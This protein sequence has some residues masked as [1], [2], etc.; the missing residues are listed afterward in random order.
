[1][2][3]HPHRSHAAVA[4]RLRLVEGHVRSVVG[5][6]EAGRPCREIAQQMHAIERAVAE[7]KR[8]LIQDHIDHCLDDAAEDT[9]AARRAAIAEFK[10]IARYL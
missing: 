10:Q 2:K 1:M 7:A 4:K 9:A 5:M 8:T 3:P 6:I